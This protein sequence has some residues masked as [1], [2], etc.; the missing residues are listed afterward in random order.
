MSRKSSDPDFALILLIFVGGT[1]WAHP[2]GMLKIAYI[3]LIV[4]FITVVLVVLTWTVRLI[5]RVRSWRPR[6]NPDT[7][8]IDTM[9]GLEFERYIARL[10]R[11]KHFHHLK[12]TEE[13]DLG[14]REQW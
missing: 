9:I 13:Y 4:S 10:L 7:T 11:S 3:A 6:Y 8:N 1:I 5:K 12:I 14:C 2:V